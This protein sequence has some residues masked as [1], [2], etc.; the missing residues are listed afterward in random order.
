MSRAS[1]QNNNPI[2]RIVIKENSINRK[3]LI[4]RFIRKIYITNF[5]R[6]SIDIYKVV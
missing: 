3:D 4:V 2:M 1:Q 6:F 5:R